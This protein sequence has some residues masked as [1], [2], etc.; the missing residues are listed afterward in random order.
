VPPSTVGCGP[1]SV[2]DSSS[3]HP[4]QYFWLSQVEHWFGLITER[5][6]RRGTFRTVAELEHAM[7]PD[8]CA[9]A[10]AFVTPSD[11]RRN[12]D[13]QDQGGEDIS[14]TFRRA[15]ESAAALNHQ[16]HRFLPRFRVSTAFSLHLRSPVN[17]SPIP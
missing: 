10:F 14:V 15:F 16:V 13:T 11:I 17:K 3:F 1:R 4:H 2:A 8:A 12:S 5:M 7:V 9:S 6:I